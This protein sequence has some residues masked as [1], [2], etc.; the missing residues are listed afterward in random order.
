MEEVKEREITDNS[1]A[2]D[3]SNWVGWVSYK[4]SSEMERLEEEGVVSRY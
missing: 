4:A 2:F 1:Y 3:L